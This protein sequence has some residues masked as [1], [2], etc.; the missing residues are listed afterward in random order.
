[1]DYYS[2]PVISPDQRWVAVARTDGSVNAYSM[3][4]GEPIHVEAWGSTHDVAGWLADGA[5]LAFERLRV[6]S[7][8]ERFDLRSG[9]VRHFMTL[10]PNDLAGVQ[11]MRRVRVTPDGRTVAFDTFRSIGTLNLFEWK[12]L[13]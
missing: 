6:P 2:R 9:T 10:A 5:L 1:V 3:E 8:I 11:R 12:P 13:R 4:G 7:R